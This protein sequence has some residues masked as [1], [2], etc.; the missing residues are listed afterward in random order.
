MA[1]RMWK[2]MRHILATTCQIKHRVDR[3]VAVYRVSTKKIT[4]N[5]ARFYATCQFYLR[6]I[7]TH[8]H[9]NVSSTVSAFTLCAC[10]ELSKNELKVSSRI[11]RSSQD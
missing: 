5:Y 11:T 2:Q 6:A 4:C 3:N 8:K 1:K 9:G 7:A 10:I